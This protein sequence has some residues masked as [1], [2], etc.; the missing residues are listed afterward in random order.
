MHL[1]T[2]ADFKR[3]YDLKLRAGDN[4][5]L[6]FCA[7]NNDVV[8]TELTDDGLTRIS[9]TRIGLSVSKKNG[10]AIRRNRIKRLLREA[11]RLSRLELPTGMDLILI[12]RP[13][14]NASLIDYQNSLR[15]LTT[16]LA[17]KL[18]RDAS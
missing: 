6:I 8:S 1:R 3:V 11:F 2:A 18:N 4:H 13:S 9:L 7:Q 5:L 10:N 15:S 12:P 17:R 14:S 16:R